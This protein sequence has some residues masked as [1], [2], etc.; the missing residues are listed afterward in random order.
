MVISKLFNQT[1]KGL[2][3]VSQSVVLLAF[4]P[5]MNLLHSKYLCGL[6]PIPDYACVLPTRVLTVIRQSQTEGTQIVKQNRH[7]G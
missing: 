7:V 1:G 5:K 4:C 3:S 2:Q 6:V